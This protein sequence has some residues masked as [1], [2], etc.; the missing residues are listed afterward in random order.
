MEGM[1]DSAKDLEN[2][3]P[4][5]QHTSSTLSFN[6]SRRSKARRLSAFHSEIVM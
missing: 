1:K 2:Q 4:P 6:T 5:R 3:H